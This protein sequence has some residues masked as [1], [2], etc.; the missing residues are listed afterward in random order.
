MHDKW[1]LYLK[2]VEKRQTL[3]MEIKENFGYGGLIHDFKNFLIRG[4]LKYSNK[5]SIK[6]LNITQ[7]IE[8]YK[9]INTI[10][11]VE[12]N[13][14]SVVQDVADQYYN[15]TKLIEPMV[16]RGESTKE[17]DGIVKINDSQALKAF[18]KLNMHFK[19]VQSNSNKEIDFI[20][21]NLTLTTIVGSITLVMVVLS[22]CLLLYRLSVPRLKELTNIIIKCSQTRNLNLRTPNVG[23]D[24]ISEA[25]S[26]FNELMVAMQQ[27]LTVV[28]GSTHKLVEV[29]AHM[30][31]QSAETKVLMLDQQSEADLLS[32]AMVEMGATA[33]QMSTNIS[34]ASVSANEA[35]QV[36]NDVDSVMNST[37]ES[38]KSLAENITTAE[39]TIEQLEVEANEIGTILEDISGI[40]E[41]TNLLALNAAIEA[42]RAGEQGRGFA[43]VADEVRSLAISTQDSTEKI[44]QKIE[45]LQSTTSESVAAM[46]HGQTLSESSVSLVQN[47]SDAISQIIGKVKSISDENDLVSRAFDQQSDV[48]NQLNINI[49]AIHD[50][51]INTLQSSQSIESTC[52]QV[53]D[54]TL[55]LEKM[56]N[57]F[58]LK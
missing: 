49:G 25:G 45:R 51:S 44:R 5:I 13:S 31:K 38:I 36:A 24:E 19:E 6:H 26:A 39:E 46:K 41:Q 10:D 47:S 12:I 50:A 55:E 53:S 4:D 2:D 34:L 42:A 32:G 28:A 18:E 43:V 57:E 29:T 16:A 17:I 8:M 21:N 20:L 27:A 30:S 37:A 15:M 3:L 11:D 23:K 54:L 9:K 35:V 22:G 14:L 52:S 56:L 58:E 1:D 48:T 40:A 7:K 33:Q